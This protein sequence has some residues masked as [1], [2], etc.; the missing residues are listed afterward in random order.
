MATQGARW[1]IGHR[2]STVETEGDFG[3]LHIIT[4]AHTPGPPPH[5]HNDAS[6]LFLIVRGTMEVTC[7]GETF[8]LSAGQSTNV[9]RGSVHT[10]RNATDSEVE[11]ITALSPRGFEAFFTE[12]GVP[13]DE[14][15]SQARSVSPEMIQRVVAGCGRLGMII[16]DMPAP[17]G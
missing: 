5:Y 12:F 11:W 13:V 9:P 7:D 10:F 17:K 15:D 1:V 2:V 16:T 4:P 3:L 14:P 8:H 6:E